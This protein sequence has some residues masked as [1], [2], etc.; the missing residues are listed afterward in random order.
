M[1][2]HNNTK[3]LIYLEHGGIG[4]SNRRAQPMLKPT[5]MAAKRSV[6]ELIEQLSAKGY[7]L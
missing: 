4:A 5:F 7:G 1:I 6:N 3:Y 2:I